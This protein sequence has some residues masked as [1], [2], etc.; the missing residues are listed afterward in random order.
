MMVTLAALCHA[1]GLDMHAAGEVELTRIWT[2]VEQ[3]RAK[4]AAKPKHSPLPGPTAPAMPAKDAWM[5]MLSAHSLCPSELPHLDKMRWM[6]QYFVE[7]IATLQGAATDYAAMEK[8]HLGDPDKA[9]GIYT[10]TSPNAHASLQ[11][12]I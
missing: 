4:Q 6:T 11:D 7:H 3:I 5:V 8:E 9:T 2:K 10:P 1:H 12:P